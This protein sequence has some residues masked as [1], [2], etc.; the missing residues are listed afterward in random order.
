MTDTNDFYDLERFIQAQAKDF[1]IALAEIN[2]GEKKSHWMWY[3]FPQLAGLG[4]SAMSQRYAIQSAAEAK[5]YLNHSVLGPRLIQCVKVL[6]EIDGRSAHEIF[7]SPDDMKLRSCATLF[8]SITP[9]GSV[10]ECLLEKY[11]HGKQDRKALDLL[12]NTNK[13]ME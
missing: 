9:K 7:G 8:A 10:F 13:S 2:N 12:K 11:F 6:L 1:A 5:A 3:I 4:H